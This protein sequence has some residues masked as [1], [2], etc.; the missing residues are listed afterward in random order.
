MTMTL[1]VGLLVSQACGGSHD[2]SSTTGAGGAG[3]CTPRILGIGD[4]LDVAVS[5]DGTL[6]AFAS[7]ADMV[8][9]LSAKDGSDVRVIYVAGVAAVAFTPDGASLVA[10]G[11]SVGRW[12]VSDGAMSWVVSVTEPIARLAMS[13]DGGANAAISA[14][15]DGNL[16]RAS[17]GGPIATFGHTAS[18]SSVAFSPDGKW[19]ATSGARWEPVSVPG[20]GQQN[21]QT[22]VAEVK[23]WD[24]GDA[25]PVTTL[26]LAGPVA[27]TPDSQS[28]ATFGGAGL[29]LLSV[30]DWTEL[31]ALPGIGGSR[32]AFTNDGARLVTSGSS[33]QV[34]RAADGTL[35]RQIDDPHHA[36]WTLAL[37]PDGTKV[38]SSVASGRVS[39]GD[40]V[41]L[42]DQVV[43]MNRLSD[44]G[45]VW[46]VRGYEGVARV[47]FSATGL[48]ASG[49]YDA[50]ARLWDPGT[51]ALL[52]TFVSDADLATPIDVA[53]IGD[54]STL[55]GG[56]SGV[57]LWRTSDGQ[58][59]GEQQN[60]HSIPSAVSVSADGR[61]L[62]EAQFPRS[63][64]FW[65]LP[66]LTVLSTF[67]ASAPMALS[68]DGALL[69][70]TE[71]NQV[72]VRGVPP[73][74]AAAP[75]LTAPAGTLAFA[76]SSDG[77]LFAT[78]GMDG[79]AHLWHMPDG[80][81]VRDLVPATSPCASVT[82]LAFS[83]DGSALAGAC[84]E[85]SVQLWRLADGS[86]GPPLFSYSSSVDSLAYSPDGKLLAASGF[87]T[88]FRI[89]CVP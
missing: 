89:L 30:G 68:P 51:G 63:L 10:G 58:P 77:Q 1:V 25:H 32:L 80:A 83:P 8:R 50:R 28:L 53:F 55:V 43:R 35:E 12:R 22:P 86:A 52:R 5:P 34:W 33:I 49:H 31:R 24:A 23:I 87:D 44:G 78:G 69:A 66:A 59:L 18:A 60:G 47:A 42:D 74:A 37:T 2:G 57:R 76:F 84:A 82:A 75:V 73:D 27:F 14:K 62:V 71:N 15:G 79:A 9:I 6:V 45:E 54:G 46:A 61:V 65:S 21:I 81:P 29:E 40:T 85:G 48:L 19:M 11:T 88:T 36:I 72:V 3:A 41:T 26:D 67:T 64:V 38:L 13:P 17:D 4:P 56:G 39:G 7:S 70:S 20:P 16:L